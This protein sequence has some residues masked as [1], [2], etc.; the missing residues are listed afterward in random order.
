METVKGHGE[1]EG[2]LPVSLPTGAMHRFGQVLSCNRLKEPSE[3]VKLQFVILRRS[4]NKRSMSVQVHV[5]AI[6]SNTSS[7]VNAIHGGH[8]G[9]HGKNEHA[10][11]SITPH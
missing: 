5:G 2:L 8:W 1:G 10:M 11:G 4:G 3:P 6:F 9:N 7:L